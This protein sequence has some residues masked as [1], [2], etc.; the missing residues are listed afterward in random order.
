MQWNE[1]VINY[2]FVHQVTLA[3]NLQRIRSVDDARLGTLPAKAPPGRSA[4]LAQRSTAAPKNRAIPSRSS[5]AAIGVLV[6]LRVAPGRAPAAAHWR[7]RAH[8]KGA[9]PPQLATLQY[10]EMLQAPRTARLAQ[11][12]SADAA[13]IRRRHSPAALLTASRRPIHRALPSR[14]LRRRRRRQRLRR[15]ADQP[16]S[17]PGSAIRQHAELAGHSERT[18]AVC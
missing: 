4:Q 14:A 16:R 8:R 3:Q 12:A 10:R 13:G 9:L 6:R 15:A 17:H 7:L 1:W 18:H 5:C 2:D 11:I